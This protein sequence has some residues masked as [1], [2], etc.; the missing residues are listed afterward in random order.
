MRIKGGV[1]NDEQIIRFLHLSIENV[2]SPS[3]ENNIIFTYNM[4][5]MDIVRL[6]IITY[7]Y[8]F[9]HDCGVMIWKKLVSLPPDTYREILNARI[10]IPAINI[11][12]EAGVIIRKSQSYATYIEQALQA[13]K[14]QAQQVPKDTLGSIAETF[15]TGGYIYNGYIE[16]IAELA[17]MALMQTA[18][19]AD[20][21]VENIILTHIQLTKRGR[22]IVDACQIITDALA[23]LSSYNRDAINILWVRYIIKAVIPNTANTNNL[24]GIIYILADSITYYGWRIPLEI[25][26]TINTRMQTLPFPVLRIAVIP[27]LCGLISAARDG[28]QL[29]TPLS[30][31]VIEFIGGD[32]INMIKI[33]LDF[34]PSEFVRIKQ[35]IHAILAEEIIPADKYADAVKMYLAW[36]ALISIYDVYDNW[37][38]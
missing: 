10:M 20:K 13:Q 19:N 35:N 38:I 2:L 14:T 3:A 16:Y 24:I 21:E 30:K 11:V 6:T 29:L 26:N 12:E 5:I 7:N 8:P 28:M 32:I 36:N 17:I 31:L 15:M 37:E 22:S 33:L 9:F 23:K 4:E 25:I 27:S 34:P 18:G 1:L